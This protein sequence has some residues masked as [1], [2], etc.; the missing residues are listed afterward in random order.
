MCAIRLNP[1]GY[2][3]IL[4]IYTSGYV[5]DWPE[6]FTDSDSGEIEQHITIVPNPRSKQRADSMANYAFPELH[7]ARSRTSK[8]EP[9]NLLILTRYERKCRMMID[10]VKVVSCY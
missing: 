2:F 6:G 4:Y 8:Q 1:Q 10:M 3:V 9:E 7:R 5:S